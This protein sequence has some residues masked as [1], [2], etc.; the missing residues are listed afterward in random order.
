MNQPR[1]SIIMGSQSDWATMQAATTVLDQLEIAYET[2]VVS[3]HRTPQRL[4]EF[5]STAHEK[6]IE[7]IIAGAGGSAHLAGMAAAMTHLPVV[8]VPVPSKHFNGMD[9]LMSMVQMPRGVAV[10]CQAV[11]EA[12]AYNAG[13]IAAQ[14]LALGNSDLSQRLQTW[15]AN[16][17]DN[18]PNEVA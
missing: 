4:Y 14:M 13:L 12:G 16:Q 6:G 10:A 15:R 5:A 8:A 1:V 9:S 11:G 2:R 3:A 7:V 17:T 18:V